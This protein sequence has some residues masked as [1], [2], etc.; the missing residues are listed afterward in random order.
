MTQEA[1]ERNIEELLSTIE[2]CLKSPRKLPGLLLLYAGIDIMA[3]LNRPKSHENVEPDDFIEWADRYL[4]PGTRLTCSALDLY[5]ARCG[6][7][8]SYIAESRRSRRGEAKMIFYA[9]GTGR[10]EELQRKLDR[11]DIPAVAMHVEVLFDAFCTGIECFK[12]SL[13]DDPERA[14]LVYQRASKFFSPMDLPIEAPTSTT[15]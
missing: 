14:N 5:G 11:S 8:H 15:T 13:A 7:I 4:L 10:A 1:F 9:W 2:D 3:W 12:Q 6:L